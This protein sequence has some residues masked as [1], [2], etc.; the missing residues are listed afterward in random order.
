MKNKKIVKPV[1]ETKFEKMDQYDYFDDDLMCKKEDKYAPFI[2]IF[3]IRFSNL[4][5]ALDSGIAELISERSDDGYAIIK[6]L[7]FSAKIE[8]FYDLAFPR[9]YYTNK[10]TQKMIRLKAIIKKL[11]TTVTLRNKIAHAKW[12]TLDK[13]GYVRVDI[14][15][16]KDDGLI[17]FKKFKITPSIIR[18]GI[19][20]VNKLAY[21]IDDFID[22]L[23]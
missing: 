17:I 19:N 5:Y 6:K 20:D 14:K 1:L 7:A 13:D 15:T 23:W 3:L 22:N 8:L 18:I 2:G 4:E 10:K 12:Y 11:E 9:V 16:D 21:K